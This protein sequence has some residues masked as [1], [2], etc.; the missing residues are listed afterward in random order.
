MLQKT[1]IVGG[2]FRLSASAKGAI[3]PKAWLVEC[4]LRDPPFLDGSDWL[5]GR[6]FFS[7]NVTNPEINA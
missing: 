4:F 2:W 3:T 6:S 1:Q 7:I 5:G